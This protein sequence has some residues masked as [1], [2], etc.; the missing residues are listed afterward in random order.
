MATEK[1]ESESMK[2]VT[3]M[4]RS[5]QTLAED[6]RGGSVAE[7]TAKVILAIRKA[8]LQTAALNLQFLRMYKGKEPKEMPLLTGSGT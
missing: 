8:Q 6:V 7:T 2:S 4:M 3:D 5:L 1:K